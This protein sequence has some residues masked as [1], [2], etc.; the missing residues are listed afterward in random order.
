MGFRLGL[1]VDATDIY[2]ASSDGTVSK[3]GLN[4]GVPSILAS[5]QAAPWNVA[6][7]LKS[8]YWTNDVDSGTIVR[9]EKNGGVPA[10]LAIGQKNPWSITVDATSVYWTNTGTFAA[11][12]L[13]G[14]VMKV[15]KNGGTPTVLAVGERTARGIAVDATSVYWTSWA[16]GY[17]KKVAK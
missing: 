6:I 15:D 1:A 13:D 12:Y 4:G 3:V 11:N 5:G 17:V 16:D 10:T 9:V 2:W 14:S 7:D 8:V